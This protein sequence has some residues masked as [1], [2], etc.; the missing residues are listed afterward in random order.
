[1]IVRFG[2]DVAVCEGGLDTPQYRKK[3]RRKGR[4]RTFGCILFNN[5]NFVVYK[6]MFALFSCFS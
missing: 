1:M 6:L 5:L 4:R 3:K 2:S